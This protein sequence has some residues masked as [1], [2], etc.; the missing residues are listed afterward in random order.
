[1]REPSPFRRLNVMVPRLRRSGRDPE[2]SSSSKEGYVREPSFLALL[3]W[4]T[5]CGGRDETPLSRCHPQ[6]TARKPAC[7]LDGASATA[8]RPAAS[9]KWGANWFPCLL[10]TARRPA[11]SH[12]GASA[13]AR[14]PAASPKWGANR[15]AYPAR[16]TPA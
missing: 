11:S 4:S 14:R 8:R 5:A 6:T 10:T 7:S 2:V 12:D 15:P 1:M 13:A 16:S 9:P 3:L